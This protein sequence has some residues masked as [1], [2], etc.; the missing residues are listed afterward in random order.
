MDSKF[1]ELTVDIVSAYV[2]RNAVPASELTNLVSDVNK[3]LAGISG[4]VAV[5]SES[6]KPAVNPKRSVHEDHLICL[7][8]GKKFKSLKRHLMSHHDF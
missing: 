7:E 2:S 8:D 3:A 6:R 4:E 5:P 1:L